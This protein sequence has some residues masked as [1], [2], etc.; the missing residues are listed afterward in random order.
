MRKNPP[1]LLLDVQPQP[2]ILKSEV[3]AALANVSHKDKPDRIDAMD[4]NRYSKAGR[5]GKSATDVGSMLR[6]T[7]Q[8]ETI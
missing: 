6:R 5:M 7:G 2:N 4:V 3:D 8:R 1:Q